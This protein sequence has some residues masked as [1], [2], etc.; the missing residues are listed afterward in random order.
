MT[1]YGD[2]TEMNYYPYGP[3]LQ[4]WIDMAEGMDKFK[5]DRELLYAL[6][7]RYL[8]YVHGGGVRGNRTPAAGSSRRDHI[9]STRGMPSTSAVPRA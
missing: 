5:T 2:T 3:L 6:A 1:E 8:D 9:Y 4:G 7:K